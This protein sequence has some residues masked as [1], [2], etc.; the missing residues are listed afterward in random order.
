[1]RVYICKV[2]NPKIYQTEYLE[3]VY[4]LCKVRYTVPTMVPI[5]LIRITLIIIIFTFYI[6][7]KLYSFY[8]DTCFSLFSFYIKKNLLEGFLKN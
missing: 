2:Y 7:I 3:L 8:N 1:M 6:M 4:Y 5:V